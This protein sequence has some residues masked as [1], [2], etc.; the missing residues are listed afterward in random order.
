MTVR[1]EQTQLDLVTNIMKEPTGFTDPDNIIVTYNSIART[2]TLTGTVNGYYRGNKITALTTGWVSSAHSVTNGQ[3][4]LVYD[5]SSFSWI[6]PASIDFS[7]ILIAFA[8]YGT[9]DK[10]ATRECHGLMPWQD[11]KQFHEIDGT[12]KSIGGTLGDYTLSSTTVAD[13][14]PSVSSTTIKDEDLTTTNAALVANGPYTQFYLSSTD[15]V[16]F[17]T[18]AT[19]IVP[20]SGNQPYYNQFTGGSW[21]QTLMTNNYYTT[22]WLVA[23]PVSSDTE[24][25]AYRYFWVQ[26]QEENFTLVAELALTTNSLNL[27]ELLNLTPELV[28]IAKV[29]I[30]YQGGNWTFIDVRSIDGTRSSQTSSPQGNYLSVVETD[31]TLTGN[32]TVSSPLSVATF[33]RSG[34][35]ILPKNAGDNLNMATGGVFIKSVASVFS[36]V[37]ATGI[38][39]I[40]DM[41]IPIESSTVGN[42][43]VTANPAIVA[44]TNGQILTLIGTDDTKTVT[45]NDG[46]GLALDNGQPFTLGQNDILEFIF[47]NSLWIETS[48]KDN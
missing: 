48:R 7:Y 46:N 21:Q 17:D 47:F 2:I 19:D 41:V 36:V 42:T 35:D 23:M 29:I 9:S 8:N 10:W 22:I 32:G 14:R 24:S 38:N 39:T 18:T 45:F 15:T 5:G 20:L 12:Y 43:T 28:F 16:N 26:G 1:K 33:Q 44:G 25:Q 37:A 11:H 13:R 31:A 3:Y 27:G 4:L 40:T 6:A 34:T 30:R